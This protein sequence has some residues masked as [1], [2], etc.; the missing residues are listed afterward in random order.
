VGPLLRDVVLT[1]VFLAL[2]RASAAAQ[3]LPESEPGRF[4]F[5]V[6]SLSWSPSFCE[7]SARSDQS[8]QCGPRPYAFVVHGLWPQFESGFPEFCQVP[9]PRLDRNIVASMLDVMPAPKLVYHEWD[10]HGTCSGMTARAYFD[11]VRKAF[12]T[13]KIPPEY[14]DLKQELVVTPEE[15]TASFAKANPDLE[16]GALTI[17]CD[18]RRL[19]EIRICLN[20]DLHFRA[21]PAANRRGCRRDT[22]L[23]PPVR[24]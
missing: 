16:P 11:T 20:K 22:I 5:Y 17:E 6:L 12:A 10:R 7:A 1:A 15:V 19:R 3:G 4:D 13:V 24:G 18:A 14:V 2:V 8:G 9:A 21:C 23:M